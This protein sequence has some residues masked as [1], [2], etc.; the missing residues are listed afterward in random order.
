MNTIELC[1][2]ELGYAVVPITGSSML[3]LLKEGRAR[4]EVVSINLRQLKKGDVVLY[5]KNNGLLVLHRIIKSKADDV[6]IVLG[7]HQVKNAECVNKQQIIA[8]AKGFYINGH[9]IS[10]NTLWYKIYKK[11]WICSLT[12]RR[13]L[14]ALYDLI[15][16]K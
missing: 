1:I 8:V 13:C 3:P 6:Y 5:K 9:Y 4:V 7:D 2:K 14:L 16:F 11:V 12:L 15:K 10:E